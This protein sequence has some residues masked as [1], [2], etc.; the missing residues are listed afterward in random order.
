MVR[1]LFR[2]RKRDRAGARVALPSEEVDEKAAREGD[3]QRDEKQDGN[4]A[5]AEPERNSSVLLMSIIA[6]NERKATIAP[7]ENVPAKPSETNASTLEQMLS[8]YAVSCITI[9][10]RAGPVPSESIVACGSRCCITL[11]N[12]QPSV[13]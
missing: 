13:K 12:R 5:F 6:P 4:R 7:V 3:A 10:D 2:G 1:P 11:A 8:T 9:T